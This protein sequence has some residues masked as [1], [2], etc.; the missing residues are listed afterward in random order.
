MTIQADDFPSALPKRL[1]A[2]APV[3]PQAQAIKYPCQVIKVREQLSIVNVAPDRRSLAEKRNAF[4]LVL[5]GRELMVDVPV[6]AEFGEA[7]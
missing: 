2:V 6:G 1:V 3:S 4:D 7:A 5:H